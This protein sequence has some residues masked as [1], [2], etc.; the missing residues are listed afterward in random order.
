MKKRFDKTPVILSDSQT[1]T[2]LSDHGFFRFDKIG[3]K[4][5]GQSNPYG[6]VCLT[7]LRDSQTLLYRFLTKPPV[8]GIRQTP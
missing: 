2:G 4:S 6:F 5:L 8:R 7:I 1:R 3:S